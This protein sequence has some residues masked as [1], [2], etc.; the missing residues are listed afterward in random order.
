MSEANRSLA[1]VLLLGAAL[2]ALGGYLIG[3]RSGGS[4]GGRGA[5][6]VALLSPAYV[7]DVQ[8]ETPP[9]WRAGSSAPTIAGLALTHAVVLSPNGQ[10]SLGGLIAG[11]VPRG[12]VAPLPASLLAQLAARP[13]TAVV[14]LSRTEAFR[15]SN[16]VVPGW[17]RPLTIYALPNRGASSTLLVCYATGA[18]P[19]TL[20]T[21][22]QIVATLHPIGQNGGGYIAPD[23]QYGQAVT[24][25]M[26][27]LGD[28][29][30]RARTEIRGASSLG[31][32]RA[33]AARLAHLFATTAA[34]LGKVEPPLIAGPAQA[35][36]VR[37]LLGAREAYEAL[38][39]A[40][41]AENGSGY[42][43]AREQATA[44]ETA[45]DTALRSYALLGY[46]AA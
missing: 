35:A 18:A 46:G 33:P 31:A 15:Y 4:G 7:A 20:G 28:E 9:D 6:P 34:A 17:K 29:R 43:T 14:G 40:A 11:E 41:G 32:A 42:E 3:H 19:A 16:V 36:L 27:A 25:A 13:T 30:V 45:V 44:A 23:A 10:T 22:E 5:P 38:A 37:A 24:A 39:T 12:E 21:C 1:T 8:L 2:A 26:H